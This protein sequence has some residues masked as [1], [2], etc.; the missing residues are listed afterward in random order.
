LVFSSPK[1]SNYN[2]FL[3]SVGATIRYMPVWSW[4]EIDECRE[5]LYAGDATRSAEIVKNAFDR[6]GGIPRHV[7]EKVGDR[8]WQSLLEDAISKVG[9]VNDLVRMDQ[10]AAS[11]E[12]SHRLLH[13]RSEAPYV[14]YTFVLGSSFICTSLYEKFASDQRFIVETLLSITAKDTGL[15]KIRGQFFEMYCHRLLANGGTFD[16]RCLKSG[17]ESTIVLEASSSRYFS[18]NVE[19]GSLLQSGCLDYLVPRN[20]NYP[21][22]D[23][24]SVKPCLLLQMTINLSHGVNVAGLSALVKV[25]DDWM[26]TQSA[27]YDL[28]FV[29][30]SDLYQGFRAQNYEFPKG[31]SY[32]YFASTLDRVSQKVLKLR[33]AAPALR[34][35]VA[36]RAFFSVFSRSQRRNQPIL[37]LSRSPEGLA[38][39]HH[40]DIV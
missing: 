8:G 7:L 10:V 34:T 5:L 29:V 30:P 16:V 2:K 12:T 35:L 3:N 39:F 38:R 15:S 26:G 23:A 6:W 28:V 1:R 18:D 21:A 24:I 33:P 32:E 17:D 40:V 31:K 14:G 4:W 37:R 20:N 36:P 25:L 11:E 22:V 9:N 13:M 27:Q 19:L